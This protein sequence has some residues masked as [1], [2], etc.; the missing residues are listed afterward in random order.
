MDKINE[1]LQRIYEALDSVGEI[2][3]SVYD[4]ELIIEY[5]QGADYIDTIRNLQDFITEKFSLED[6]ESILIWTIR[7]FPSEQVLFLY[8]MQMGKNT[9]SK[10]ADISENIKFGMEGRC[11]IIT[12]TI[13]VL[14]YYI[15]PFVKVFSS[16][17]N[18]R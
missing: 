11:D 18:E 3:T 16:S 14:D 6:L 17:L 2:K 1:A 12:G 8:M 13:T 9:W 4:W 5:C 7:W 10:I 15:E